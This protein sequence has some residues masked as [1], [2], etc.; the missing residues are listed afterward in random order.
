MLSNKIIVLVGITACFG[1]FVFL[2]GTSEK[3]SYYEI[4]PL[5]KIPV[6]QENAGITNKNR[7]AGRYI[8]NNVDP[9]L[10][11][12]F[13]E[14]INND[15]NGS[16]NVNYTSI[17]PSDWKG[18]LPSIGTVKVVVLLVDFPD[19]PHLPEQTVDCVKSKFFGDGN[20]NNYPYESLRNYYKRS[21]YEKLDIRGSVLGWYTA[22]HS[23]DYYEKLGEGYGHEELIKETLQ[24]Y[25][26]QHDFSQ[27]DNDNDG[28]LD[29]VYIKWTGPDNG[30]GNFYWA[31]QADWEKDTNFTLNGKKVHKYIWDWYNNSRR[32]ED[33]DTVRTDI[34]ETGHI[35]GLPDYYDYNATIGPAGGVGGLDM[36]DHNWGDHNPFSKWLLG[37]I[38]P[39]IINSS[40]PNK[41][42]T[43]H[44]SGTSEEAVVIM[45][46]GS[47]NP[48]HE[49]FMVQY[50]KR[51]ANDVGYPTDGLLIWHVDG[52]LNENRTNYLYDNSYTEHKL[53]RLMEA[54]G[55]EKIEHI[56]NFTTDA[57]TFYLPSHRFSFATTPNSND[58]AGKITGVQVDKITDQIETMRAF[59]GFCYPKY[60][61]LS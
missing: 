50:R 56:K 21:S 47:L 22:K 41:F 46:D 8:H 45:P 26:K 30:W 38:K 9:W 2:N 42:I 57:G 52:T 40:T 4:S 18:G 20:S 43:L 25:E 37:W 3:I 32:G 19:Y 13:I 39:T 61:K 34:H 11:N 6:T 54:D 15:T 24:F 28:N 35:L 12:K 1:L 44:P 5:D 55:L 53:L 58:Y 16:I 17:L 31:F 7:Y 14:R 51:V 33:L 27:Y 23:R 48:F 29:A 36:M 60:K 49:F 10:L 59:F